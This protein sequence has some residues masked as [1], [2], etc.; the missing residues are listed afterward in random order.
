MSAPSDLLQT[1]SGFR[2][3]RLNGREAGE[4]MVVVHYRHKPL[5]IGDGR[6]FYQR[7]LRRKKVMRLQEV[8][9]PGVAVVFLFV[10][11]T[12]L[13]FVRPRLLQPVGQGI[14]VVH[15]L[16]A[17]F[18]QVLLVHLRNK[19]EGVHVEQKQYE[20]HKFHGRKIKSGIFPSNVFRLNAK[21]IRQA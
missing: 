15:L 2:R 7:K 14:N 5:A 6:L 10:V 19:Q 16:A 17:G 18:T 9:E 8:K 11:G 21:N 4:K 13:F 1:V 3:G 12:F 20:D